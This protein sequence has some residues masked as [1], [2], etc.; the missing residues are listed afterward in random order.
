MQGRVG[1]EWFG[2]TVGDARWM[3]N[4]NG[5]LETHKTRGGGEN[6][7]TYF[8]S[9]DASNRKPTG[10]P[11]P[12]RDIYLLCGYNAVAMNVASVVI[13]YFVNQNAYNNR[14]NITDGPTTH[15]I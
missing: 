10:R 4:N 5:K 9:H 3:C 15:A 14:T 7:G 12:L 2:M 8:L 6:A 13:K 1:I 11:P